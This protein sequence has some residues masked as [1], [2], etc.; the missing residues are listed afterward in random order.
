MS[1]FAAMLDTLFADPNMA[2]DALYTPPDGSP[3]VPCRAQ[4]RQPDLDWR[5]G[6]ASIGTPSRVAEV[7]VSE[8]PVMEEEGGLSIGGQAYTIQKASRP[9]RARLLWRLELR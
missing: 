2:V 7:R 9:D 3:A 8:I 1:A 4:L 5:G 6:D